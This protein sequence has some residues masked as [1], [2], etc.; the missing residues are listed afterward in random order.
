MK[1][2]ISIASALIAVFA[3]SVVVMASTVTY[4]G[5]LD[6]EIEDGGPVPASLDHGLHQSSS[7]QVFSENPNVTVGVMTDDRGLSFGPGNYASYI[8]HFDNNESLDAF[9]AR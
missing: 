1:K 4:Y 3:L 8:L 5:T 9:A 2:P 7:V 6:G